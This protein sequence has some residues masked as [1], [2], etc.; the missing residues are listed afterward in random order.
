MRCSQ[1][2][3]LFSSLYYENY[4]LIPNTTANH[5]VTNLFCGCWCFQLWHE[6][7]EALATWLFLVTDFSELCTLFLHMVQLSNWI[8]LSES[9]SSNV[10]NSS[11]CSVLSPGMSQAE[12]NQ[13][14]SSFY[15]CSGKINIVTLVKCEVK[16]ETLSQSFAYYSFCLSKIRII[17]TKNTL[18]VKKGC[19]QDLKKAVMKKMCFVAPGGHHYQNF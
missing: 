12:V 11:G 10:P 18:T 4:V 1:P 14:V 7:S 9:V 5:T 3:L 16:C 15:Q 19:G 13:K 17:S 8:S 2:L 6:I